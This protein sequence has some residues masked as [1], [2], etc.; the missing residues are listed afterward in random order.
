MQSLIILSIKYLKKKKRFSRYFLCFRQLCTLL[1]AEV[2][3]KAFSEALV[4]E[5][6]LKFISTMIDYLNTILL[7]SSEL[8]EL[9]NKLKDLETEDSR[10]LF[11]SLYYCWC[12]NPVATVALCLLSQNYAH[13]CELIRKLYLFKLFTIFRLGFFYL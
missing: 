5:T 11:E 3:Y 6:N 8:F 10:A 12:H 4:K 13:A 2:I 9:R 7:T 1:N